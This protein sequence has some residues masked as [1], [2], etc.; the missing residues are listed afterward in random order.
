[1]R[2]YSSIDSNQAATFSS[3]TDVCIALGGMPF[4]HGKSTAQSFNRQSSGSVSIGV[5]SR[6][7][8]YSGR[9]KRRMWLLTV[10]KLRY[11]LTRSHGERLLLDA[12]IRH[13]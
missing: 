8:M 6:C 13:E 9:L 5:K 11:T 12:C 2:L 1:M 7:A 10:H 3:S 4:F